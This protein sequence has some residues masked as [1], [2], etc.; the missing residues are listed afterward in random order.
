V[1]Q[2]SKDL[3]RWPKIHYTTDDEYTSGV[4]LTWTGETPSSSTV[5]RATEP[6]FGLFTIAVH[7]AMASLPFT[8]DFLEDS[9]FDVV[10]ISTDLMAEAFGLGENDAF[11]NGTGIARP[12]GLLTQVDGDGPASVKSGT[13]S[14]LTADGLIDLTYAIP[15]QYDI[16]S[17]FLFN[18][19][20]EK[21]IRKLKTSGGDYVWPIVQTQGQLAPTPATLL[22]YPVMRDEFMPDVGANTYPAIFG[23]LRGYLVIDRVG[24]SVQRLSEL[25]AETNITVLLARKRVGGQ[26]IEPW[27]LRIH[28]VAA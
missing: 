1:V 4:R 11:I 19:A 17:R 2:T 15:A 3:A 5:H 25:Y 18:K 27:R 10:G 20:T 14:T 23:D 13:A 12:M 9:E 21:V 24:F 8:N 7:T 16:N 26:C 28:K 6:V 22:G